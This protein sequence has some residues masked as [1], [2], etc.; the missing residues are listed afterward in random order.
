MDKSQILILLIFGIGLLV[1]SVL[2]RVFSQAKYE[3]KTISSV[4]HIFVVKT[5]RN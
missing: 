2:L 3:I 4:T 1:D 5:K